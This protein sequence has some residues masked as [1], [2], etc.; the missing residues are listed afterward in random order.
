MGTLKPRYIFI[1]LLV[2]SHLSI[3]ADRGFSEE[4]DDVLE[5]DLEQL[6]QMDVVVTSVSKRPQRLHTTAS[7]IYVVTQEDIRRTGATN[8]PEALRVVPGVL[9]SR[10]DQNSYAVSIRGFNRQFASNKLLVM[11]DGRKIVSPDTLGVRWQNQDTLMED[12]DRIEVIRGPGS[13][14]WGSNS[15]AGVIHIITKSAEQTQG[16]LLSGGGGT[17]EKGFGS[18]R[19]GGKLG[20]NFFYRVYAKYRDEDESKRTDGSDAFDASKFFQTGL[21]SDW[22]I[23]SKD[24]LTVQGDYYTTDLEVDRISRTVSFTAPQN[25]SPFKSTSTNAGINLLGRWTRSLKKDSAFKLQAYYDHFKSDT[26]LAKHSYNNHFEIDLQH[27]FGL[28]ENHLLSWGLNYRYTNIEVARDLFIRTANLETN[29]VGIFIQ[30]EITLIPQTWSV[31]LGSKFEHNDFTGLEVQPNIRTVWTPH[32][33]HTL[34]AA[35]TRGVRIPGQSENGPTTLNVG[36]GI[37]GPGLASVIR[38]TG[39]KDVEAEELLAF[40]VGY[41]AK[42]RP[43]LSLDFAAYLFEYDNLIELTV[44]TSFLENV[45]APPHV[46]TPLIFNNPI[47]GEAYGVEF[48]AKWQP[49]ESWLLSGS[50]SYHSLDLRSSDPAVIP[51]GFEDEPNHI[52]N[53][54][55]FLSLPHNLEFDS[56]LYYVSSFDAFNIDGYTR[57]DLRLGWK[58]TKTFELSL[59]GQNLIEE[60]HREHTDQVI[61]A[62]ETQRSVIAKATFRFK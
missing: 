38:I 27:D 60:Q 54:R 52:F 26:E 49:T 8:I 6:M 57:L 17:E 41:R 14:I 20:D 62:T 48:T 22:Q 33:N 4:L 23:N 53:V 43:D 25:I 32:Q 45:P 47:E 51:T 29:L 3:L 15:V 21:R 30:D 55:S 31:I 24:H 9:V 1:L 2:L 37:I 39:N 44:G 46:V 18:L 35:V 11:I 56:M 5:M 36:G 61:F 40:E 58:P 59:A 7:A 16:V 13:V 12:I 28:L 10:V 50:Y 19:Y 42:L 34:W